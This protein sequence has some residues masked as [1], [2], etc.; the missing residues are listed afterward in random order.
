MG[1]N[2][3]GV[4]AT[5]NTMQYVVFQ[6]KDE[7]Y[8]IDI[9]SVQG[10]EK[11]KK[12][13]RVPKALECIKGVMNLRGEIIPVMSLR[14]RFEIEDKEYDDNTRIIIIRLDDSL[15]GLIVDEVIE[16]IELHTDEIENVQ[17]IDRKINLDYI[18]GVGKMKQG[19]KVIT[20]LN[21]KTLIEETL[22]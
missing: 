17:S 3:M 7:A 4:E 22:M 9:Q 12:F 21:L 8:G 13:A 5:S 15:I 10:I 20:L 16:V 19:T 14:T 6:L 2:G 18:A 1:V 11:M